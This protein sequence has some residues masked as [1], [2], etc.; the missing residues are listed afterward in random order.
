MEVK[1][2]KKFEGVFGWTIFLFKEEDENEDGD[3]DVRMVHKF[4]YFLLKNIL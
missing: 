2:F 3:E 1:L 4:I